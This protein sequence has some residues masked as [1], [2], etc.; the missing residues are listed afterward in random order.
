MMLSNIKKHVWKFIPILLILGPG[1][2]SG[3]VDNDAGGIATYSIAGG[4]FADETRK[5]CRGR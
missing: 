1:I 4:Q 2:I 5:A 3:S